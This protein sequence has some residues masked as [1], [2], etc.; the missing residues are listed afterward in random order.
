MRIKIKYCGGCN[1]GI[2]RKQLVDEIIKKLQT[3]N[4]IQFTQDE[5]DAGLVVCGCAAACVAVDRIG[6]KKL[7]LVA[8]NSVNYYAVPPD[9]MTTHICQWLEEV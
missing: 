3:T 4:P 5:E 6:A 8:G 1:T 9:R 2:N 7:I